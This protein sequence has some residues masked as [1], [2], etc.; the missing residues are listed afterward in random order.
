MLIIGSCV[1]GDG[2]A[3]VSGCSMDCGKKKKCCKK[4]KKKGKTNC[5]R[6]PRLFD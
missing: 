2:G 5:K 1:G 6:C 3:S 4:F